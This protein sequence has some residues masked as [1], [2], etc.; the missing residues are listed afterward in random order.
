[1][2]VVLSTTK[3]AEESAKRWTI[4]V[5]DD[6]GSIDIKAQDAEGNNYY[7][8]RLHNDGTFYRY[9]GIPID[10]GFKLTKLDQLVES[11]NH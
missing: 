6:G 10:S 8:L 11:K 4:S 7:L 2:A 3:A 1:M 5:E 9:E